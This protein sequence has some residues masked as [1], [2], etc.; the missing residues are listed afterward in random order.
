MPGPA[1]ERL[2]DHY[3]FYSVFQTGTE[4]RVLHGG[5]TLGTLPVVSPLAVDM[6]IIFSGRR[7][8]VAAVVDRERLIEVEPA[9]AGRP[10]PFGGNGGDLHDTVVEAMR[11]LYTADDVPA[12][13]DATARSLLAEGRTAFAR[14]RLDRTGLIDDDGDLWLFPWVGTVKLGTLA[15][16]LRAQGLDA[17]PRGISIGIADATADAVDTALARIAGSPPPDPQDLAEAA[18]TRV[19]GKYDP[20]L[21]DSLLL[22]SYASQ[23]IDTTDLPAIAAAVR[24]RVGDTPGNRAGGPVQ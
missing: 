8:R 1:G 21:T 2:V 4:Y 16:A 12:F 6:T 15:L 10:P 18:A 13:L 17:A 19:V 20:H 11:A 14:H 23:R 24:R 9:R 3:D 5:T 7:W 22:H